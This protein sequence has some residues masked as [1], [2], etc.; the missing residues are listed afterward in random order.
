M[1]NERYHTFVGIFVAGALL[2]LLTGTIYFYREYQRAHRQTFVMFF[3][4]TLNGLVAGAPVTYRG[5]KIGEIRLIE[6]TENLDKD[7]VKLP[8]YV[9]FFVEKSFNFSQDPINLLIKNGYVANITKPNLLTGIASIELIQA[10]NF[11]KNTTGSYRDYPIF[12]TRNT[13]EEYT[14]IDEAI[15]TAQKT[16][17]DISKFFQSKQLKDTIQSTKEMTNS[18]DKLARDF[19]QRVPGLAITTEQSLNEI[20][21]AASATKNLANYLARNPESLL[22]GRR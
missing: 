12:P 19:N 13:I 16:L 14:S 6:I 18:V 5:V 20:E 10:P 22:R 4:G 2:I 21:S 15:T 7:N 3:K 8:V 9:N 11:I 1:Q 17:E